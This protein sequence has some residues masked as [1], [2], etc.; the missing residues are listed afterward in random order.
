MIL[1]MISLFKEQLV[2]HK[3]SA[4]FSSVVKTSLRNPR[5]PFFFQPL[6]GVIESRLCR[7]FVHGTGSNQKI[8]SIYRGF[9]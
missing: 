5:F 9:Q 8:D 3:R 1:E 2:A 6:G 7:C 4:I